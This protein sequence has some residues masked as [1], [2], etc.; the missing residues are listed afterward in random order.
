MWLDYLIET[1]LVIFSKRMFK[2]FFVKRNI[3]V[4]Q[5]S[6]VTSQNLHKKTPHSH[7]HQHIE[8]LFQQTTPS[9]T[10]LNVTTEL[11]KSTETYSEWSPWSRC[12]ECIQR[13]MRICTNH[14]CGDSRIYEERP[15]KKK[16]CKRKAR[17]KE[18]FH[19]VHLNEVSY[20]FRC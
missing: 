16:R 6:Q 2:I 14:T 12:Q 20:C 19:I 18:K 7:Y 13:R 3:F 5:E 1:R 4:L 11:S 15:C 9:T 8:D 10:F 17:N